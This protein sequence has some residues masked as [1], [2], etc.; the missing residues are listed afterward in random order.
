MKLI[1]HILDH[2][3]DGTESAGCP[4]PGCTTV[5]RS[6]GSFKTHVSRYHK[7][8]KVPQVHSDDMELVPAMKLVPAPELPQG[9]PINIDTGGEP[10][11]TQCSDVELYTENYA[12]S[13]EASEPA[14]CSI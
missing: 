1:S 10:S 2:F 4:C 11:D 14:A 8:T 7:E 3:R 12:V 6:A 13:V 9:L 5:L